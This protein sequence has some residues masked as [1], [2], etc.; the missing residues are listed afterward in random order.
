MSARDD[1]TELL[2]TY[3]KSLNTSD[4]AL[5]ASCYTSDGM[6]MPTTLPTAKGG[7]MQ[8]A[9]EKTFAAIRLQVKFTIDELVVASDEIAFALTRSNGTQ[10][11]LATGASGAESNREMFIFRRD[12]GSWKIARYM[13]NKSH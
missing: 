11:I 3:E 6:F 9:Y 8:D 7:A 2:K 1:I 12:D 4:A 10:T 5:A 13:F